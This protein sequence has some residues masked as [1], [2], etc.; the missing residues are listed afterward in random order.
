MKLVQKGFTLIEL[1]IVVAIIGILAAV[2]IPQYQDYVVRAKLS[3]VAAVADPV[4]TA[5]ADFYQSNGA[6][7]AAMADG[8]DWSAI[9]MSATQTIATTEV[10]KVD[11]LANGVVQLTLQ[12]VKPT[13]IDGKTLSLTPTVTNTSISWVASSTST[14][15]AL[16][17]AISTWK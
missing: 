9:G 16:L 14:D 15:P 3:K 5:L 8:G 1:M 7:P 6:F 11:V 12:G 4:K 13:A 2:A 10:T 17:K